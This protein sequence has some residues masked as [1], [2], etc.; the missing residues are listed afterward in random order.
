[1]DVYFA[2]LE[3]VTDAVYRRVHAQRFGG[4]TK[5]FTPFVSPT[6]DLRLTPKELRAIAP[7][8]GLFV[9]PQLLA[10]EPEPLLWACGALA[11]MGYAE[12]NLNLGCPSGTVTAKG[13]GAGLLRDAER[14]ARL[15]DAVCPRLPLRLSVKTRLGYADPG[16]FPALLKLLSRYPLEEIIV[17]A[18]TREEYYRGAPHRDVFLAA[19]KESRLPLVYNGDLFTAR[20]CEAM[21]SASPA[22]AALMI[23]RGLIANPALA[24]E[25]AGGAPIDVPSLRGYV[26]ALLEG[27]LA[28]HPPNVAVARTAQALRYV[29]CCF[30]GAEKPVKLLRKAKTLPALLE[31]E[32]RLF[33]CALRKEP[34]YIPET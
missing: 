22:P 28:A 18:R 16:E 30:E 20:D 25:F 23:G 2:P 27:W 5:Y 14:L 15:L 9:V 8:A 11:G 17:H 33:E 3:G 32:K 29:A 31:A 12:A 1:M 6:A 21:Q 26:D 7:Q 24:R 19:L 13:K 10:R 4:V 34:G